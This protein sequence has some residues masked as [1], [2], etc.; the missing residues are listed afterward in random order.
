MCNASTHVRFTPNSDTDCIFRHV[1]ASRHFAIQLSC[2]LYPK[3]RHSRCANQCPLMRHSAIESARVRSA[4]VKVEQRL[5]TN[6]MTCEDCGFELSLEFAFCPRCGRRQARSSIEAVSIT[7]L[8][9]VLVEAPQT[10]ADRRPVTVLFADVCGFTSFAERLDPED[11]R[12]FQSALFETLTRVIGRYNGFVTKFMG[13][14][15]LALFGAPV[16]HENDPERALDA[17]LDILASGGTLSD[18]WS[19]RLG[20]PVTMHVAVHSG[21]VV[22][23]SLPDS[24]GGTYDVTGDTV[25]T[26]ARLLAIA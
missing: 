9:P 17:A 8:Q 22:A 20:Q 25:N 21:P 16:A 4:S 1:C 24:A 2:P 26:A 10:H 18:Q 19:A 23:G 12:A 14:A 13:D 15:V 7:S 3:S 5:A 11:V 6:A